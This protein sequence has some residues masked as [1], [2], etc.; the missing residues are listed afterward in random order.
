MVTHIVPLSKIWI[1]P[2]LQ[3]V[4]EKGFGQICSSSEPE[5]S[6]GHSVDSVHLTGLFFDRIDFYCHCFRS[7]ETE[8]KEIILAEIIICTR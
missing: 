5:S 8:K 1:N 3:S 7:N 2:Q 6:L 4:C